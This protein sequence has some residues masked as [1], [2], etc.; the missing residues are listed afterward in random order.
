MNAYSIGIEIVNPRSTTEK[1]DPCVQTSDDPWDKNSGIQ[2]PG[3]QEY[4]YPFTKA[5]IKSLIALCQELMQRYQIPPQNV[6]GQS[7]IAPDPGHISCLGKYL[8][9]TI[10]VFGLKL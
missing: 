5:Q 8:R 6:L 9:K 4:W 1:K 2:I 7:D 3:S 10:L